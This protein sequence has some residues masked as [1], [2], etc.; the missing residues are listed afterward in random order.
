M[1][2]AVLATFA[3]VLL[4]GC[5]PGGTA[6]TGGGGGSSSLVTTISISLTQYAPTS[7]QYGTSGGY[8]PAVTTVPVGSHIRFVNNDSFAHTATA[9][10]G[11]TRFPSSSPFTISATTQHGTTLSG[12]F[13]AGA[14][15][16]GQT[17]QLILVD[18]KGT[19]LFGCFYHYGA[20]MRAAI[21]AQ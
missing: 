1:H 9:I 13:S 14:L 6:A 10:P 17:S 12:G 21:V 4:G 20:P 11:A 15:Q 2:R 3:L 19:Y 8:A 16:P 5:T 18:K 7:T